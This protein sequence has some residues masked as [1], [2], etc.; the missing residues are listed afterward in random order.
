MQSF[1]SPTQSVVDWASFDL[2]TCFSKPVEYLMTL[3]FDPTRNAVWM[4]VHFQGDYEDAYAAVSLDDYKLKHLIYAPRDRFLYRY[5]ALHSSGT[6]LLSFQ[7]PLERSGDNRV[8][9]HLSECHLCVIPI[10][11]EAEAVATPST[12]VQ[13]YRDQEHFTSAITVCVA[14]NFC[15]FGRRTNAQVGFEIDYDFETDALRVIDPSPSGA[16]P[17]GLRGSLYSYS[18]DWQRGHYVRCCSVSVTRFELREHYEIVSGDFH[19]E[20]KFFISE[21]MQRCLKHCVDHLGRI[22][23]VPYAANRM[24]VHTNDCELAGSIELGL[25]VQ[26]LAFN[27]ETGDV[28]ALTSDDRLLHMPV[29]SVVPNTFEWLPSRH[30]YAPPAIDQVVQGT[31]GA[32]HAEP[33]SMVSLMD[34][35][36][37]HAVFA[38]L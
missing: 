10:G 15:G 16:T 32:W 38:L 2:K 3:T 11:D 1:T 4:V 37:L 24:T 7:A 8:T 27:T 14:D 21:G 13:L 6:R 26:S 25:S 29:D 36:L 18:I 23:M 20:W 5:F 35:S 12:T 9:Y 22:Y 31:L 34:E 17:Y 19:D 28:L 30:R 33:D